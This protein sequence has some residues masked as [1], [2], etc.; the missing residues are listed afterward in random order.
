MTPQ[1]ADPAHSLGRAA[2]H[3]HPVGAVSRAE[4]LDQGFTGL[5]L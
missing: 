3:L 5:V 1:R 2:A 4:V